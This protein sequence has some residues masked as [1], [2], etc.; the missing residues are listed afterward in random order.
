MEYTVKDVSKLTG[1]T[2]RTLH[3]YDK[4]GLLKP[5]S[6]TESNYR[7]YNEESL[8]KLEQILFF[9]EL[10]FDLKEIKNVLEADIIS[11]DEIFLKQKKLL[12]LKKERLDRIINLIDSKIGGE[13]KMSFK[14]FENTDY[15]KAVNDYKEE[16]K[17]RW[18]NTD[19]YKESAEKTKKYTKDDFKKIEEE[20]KKIYLEFSNNM[21]RDVRDK[22]IKE[23]VK[24]WQD[25]ITKYFYNCTTEILK[26]LGE[27][28]VY[29]ERFKKNIDK[30]K[31]GLAEYMSLAIKEYCS[32]IK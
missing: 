26:G 4:I 1:I 27:M 8:V 5:Y 2:I 14:E 22:E 31:D 7:I 29:D 15:E 12:V 18:G 20:A 32:N 16:V 21:Y 13:N 10:D 9:K 3:W 6:K 30:Y 23:I 28:Y 25:Y 11:K 24:K 19:A 17:N